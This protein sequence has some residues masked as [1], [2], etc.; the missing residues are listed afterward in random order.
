MKTIGIIAE[1]NPFHTGHQY[2][3]N[4]TKE[5]TNADCVIVIMSGNCVQR[6][7]PAIAD[8]HTRAKAA[9]LGGADLV[10]ALPVA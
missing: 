8:K 5:L 2:H 1:Y 7:F 10:S 4:K 3:I 9:L 6:G